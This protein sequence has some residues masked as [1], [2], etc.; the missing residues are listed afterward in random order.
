[1]ETNP[2][3]IAPDDQSLSIH[4]C[5]SPMREIEVLKD[6]LLSLFDN[7]RELKPHDIIVMAPDIETYAPYLDAVFGT[8]SPRMPYRISDRSIRHG[9]P[10]IE[11][12]LAIIDMVQGRA[13][14]QEVLDLLEIEVVREKFALTRDDLEIAANWTKQ[15]GIRWGMDAA[16]R[17]RVGHPDYKE[18]TWQ[19]GLDRLLLGYAMPLGNRRLYAGVLPY[20]E[21]EGPEALILG[22]YAT[23]INA[24]FRELKT[25]RKKRHPSEWKN[26]LTHTLHHMVN[27]S[28]ENSDQHKRILD[29]LN[30]LEAVAAAAD[31]SEPIQLQLVRRFLLEHLEKDPSAHGFLRNGI[32]CC[33]LLPMRSIPFKVVC[34]IG[35]NE[36]EFPRTYKGPGF[37]KMVRTP[38]RGDRSLRSDDRY[39]FLESLSAARHCFLITYIGRSIVD[40]GA[41]PPSVLVDELLD[42]IQ[43]GF[44]L[45]T[46]PPGQTDDRVRKRLVVSHPLHPFSPSYF[47]AGNDAR[48]FSYSS[49]HL[50]SAKALTAQ[51]NASAQIF[52]EPLPLTNNEKQLVT[53][54]DLVSFYHMPCR[55]LVK[56]RLG[57]HLLDEPEML[58][59][60]EPVQLDPLREY[61]IGSAMLEDL[62][63]GKSTEDTF[64]ILKAMGALPLG[65]VGKCH[66][67]TLAERV[68][69]FAERIGEK[70]SPAGLEP[71]DV[72][73]EL[74]G[75]RLV[76]R[77]ENMWQDGRIQHR[78]A[79]LKAKNRLE[80]W[81][82]HLVL[83]CLTD[84]SYP[85]NSIWFGRDKNKKIASTAL[86][87]IDG[88]P[89]EILSDLVRLYWLGQTEPLRFFPDLSLSF[90]KA[91]LAS[92]LKEDEAKSKA[93][94]DAVDTWSATR[95]NHEAKDPAITHAFGDLSPITTR[96]HDPENDFSEL[97]LSIF[98]PLIHHTS[99]VGS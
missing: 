84:T 26:A 58:D 3:V 96:G 81:I 93:V 21:I 24:L 62:I 36:G 95:H 52:T 76:G 47:G 28:L 42:V 33:S 44:C 8:S 72:A 53:L 94:R 74:D 12:F 49:N 22:R 9:A 69:A 71:L 34:L 82:N 60:R 99:K 6:R 87:P 79:E 59:T 7:D 67:E 46:P 43:G 5:H 25:L 56:K 78:Y 66:Y 27:Q 38:R 83:N 41:L 73:L 88:N 55:Y 2:A 85:K 30:Q 20:D 61:A 31:F 48:L 17:Q 92:E 98:S 89:K 19:F 1:M 45:E 91:V 11:A 65:S 51:Q 57:L 63:A 16:H 77:L 86:S 40:G 18:N 90:A 97:A 68:S 32:T 70:I 75:T 29:T 15:A 23:A 14:I 50:E 10:V 80:L 37:D 13:T 39:L 4:A 64:S 54:T 35:M